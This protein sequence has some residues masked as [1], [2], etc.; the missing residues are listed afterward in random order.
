MTYCFMC[1]E[2]G[3]KYT[4]TARDHAGICIECKIGLARDYRAEAVGVGS[5]VRQVT[6]GVQEAR[7][8]RTWAERAADAEGL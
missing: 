3:A 1:P 6:K 4:S 2:C 5:G 8:Y 7:A